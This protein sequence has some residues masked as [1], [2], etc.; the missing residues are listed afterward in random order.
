MT[1]ERTRPR[2]S[3]VCTNAQGLTPSKLLHHLSWL[4]E[5]R[6]DI[7]VLTET[8]TNSSPEALLRQLPGAGATWPGATFFSCPG[9]GHTQG[10]C[11]ILGPNSPLTNPSI[12]PLPQPSGRILGIDADLNGSPICLVAVYAPTQPSE[13]GPFFRDCLSS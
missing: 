1:S 7:A 2:L 12:R 3:L 9:T 5:R 4:R 13:R 8:Q 10:I 11:V 6:V